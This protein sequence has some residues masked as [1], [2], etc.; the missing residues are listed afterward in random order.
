MYYFT[1]ATYQKL[2]KVSFD[3]GT[4]DYATEGG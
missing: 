3:A 1:H 2:P 4:L